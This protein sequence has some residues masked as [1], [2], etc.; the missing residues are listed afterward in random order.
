M[1]D[2]TMCQ[3]T[4]CPARMTC[5]RFTA[6]ANNDRQSYAD[7]GREKGGSNCVNFESNEGRSGIHRDLRPP[8]P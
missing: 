5:H 3:D 1:A 2:I 7:F 6:I 4:E 8:W